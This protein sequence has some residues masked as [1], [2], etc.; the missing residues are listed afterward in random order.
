MRTAAGLLAPLLL[1]GWSASAEPRDQWYA[2]ALIQEAR[3]TVS[4]AEQAFRLYRQAAEAGLPEAQFNV[5]VMLDSGRGAPRDLPQAALWYG[6]AAAHGFGR[7]AYNLAQLYEAGDGV[8]RNDALA[9]RWY[10]ASRLPAARDRAG[11]SRATEAAA[12]IEAP[13]LAPTLPARDCLRGCELVWTSGPQPSG[14]RF[15]VEVRRP[16]GPDS[17]VL[18]AVLETSSTLVTSAQSGAL[19]WRVSAV[20]D[21]ARTY[22]ASPWQPLA[23][24]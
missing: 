7:A 15:V 21:G 22:A 4:G 18:S 2:D 1:L 3:G 8:P 5:A 20:N 14:T 11:A 17:L 23:G 6:R 9:R 16:A 24:E 12:S 19:V 13:A 10:A